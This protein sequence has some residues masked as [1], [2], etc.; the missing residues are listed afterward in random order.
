MRG[1][2]ACSLAA[3]ATLPGRPQPILIAAA[4]YALVIV[5][6]YGKSWY[7]LLYKTAGAKSCVAAIKTD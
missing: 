1:G 2:A 4:A 6:C 3:I 5:A 7:W